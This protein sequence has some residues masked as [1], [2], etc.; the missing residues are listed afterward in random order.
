MNEGQTKL[1]SRLTISKSMLY[2]CVSREASSRSY[3]NTDTT[4]L[5]QTA[6]N[7]LRELMLFTSQI[8]NVAKKIIARTE[9]DKNGLFIELI[10]YHLCKSKY[11]D[12]KYLIQYLGK[13]KNIDEIIQQSSKYETDI[14]SW[15]KLIM[16]RKHKPT[17]DER[18]P[19]LRS[20]HAPKKNRID[21]SAL[22][23]CESREVAEDDI[24]EFD[25]YINEMAHNCHVTSSTF[26]ENKDTSNDST[27][28]ELDHLLSN[29]N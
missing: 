1:R 23:E 19:E 29:H 28:Q 10:K 13:E 11:E 14:L 9:T 21:F 15:S 8:E 12:V 4:E 18:G 20:P 26:N 17:N 27:M 6:K 22:R 24:D 3:Y 7:H 5:N 2:M 25:D 16:K